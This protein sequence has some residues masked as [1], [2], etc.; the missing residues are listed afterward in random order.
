MRF[1]TLA[2]LLSHE[3]ARIHLADVW[4]GDATDPRKVSTQ[5]ISHGVL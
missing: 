2:P 4:S 5:L 3:A 1:Q